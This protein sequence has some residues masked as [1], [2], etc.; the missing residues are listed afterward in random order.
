MKGK[1]LLAL[2]LAAGLAVPAIGFA[3]GRTETGT[4]GG[5]NDNQTST[6]AASATDTD[7]STS[8]KTKK[9]T[10][11][12]RESHKNRSQKTGSESVN[13][14]NQSATNQDV[15]GGNG[16]FPTTREPGY[17]KSM[18]SLGKRDSL[19]DAQRDTTENSGNGR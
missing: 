19:L 7:T 10:G 2:T 13:A 3:Q 5:V 9:K 15:T 17:R 16:K 18:S 11:T 14:T 8:T 6:R 4:G 12:I 1:T